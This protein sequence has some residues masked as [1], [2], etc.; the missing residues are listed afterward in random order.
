MEHAQQQGRLGLDLGLML[1]RSTRAGWGPGGL[2]ASVG[3]PA[4]TQL[5]CAFFT[6]HSTAKHIL[7]HVMLG[8]VDNS[9]RLRMRILALVTGAA[10]R[11]LLPL[12]GQACHPAEQHERL[13]PRRRGVLLRHMLTL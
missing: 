9:A 6:N 10:C 8:S 2:L 1:G 5:W 12:D 11:R 3:E 7:C 13:M 4:P